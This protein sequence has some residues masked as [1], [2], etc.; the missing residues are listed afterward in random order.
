MDWD[1]ISKYNHDKNFLIRFQDQLNWKLLSQY[2]AFTTEELGMFINKVDWKIISQYQNLD[3]D[4]LQLYANFLDWTV[5]SKYQNLLESWILTFQDRIDWEEI[6]KRKY[7][8]DEF[9]RSHYEIF[10][11]YYQEKKK[12]SKVPSIDEYLSY[13]TVKN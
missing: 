1:E 5:V 12:V 9:K 4:Y 7:I 10:K 6:F 3:I 11:K 8:R 2:H 13:K